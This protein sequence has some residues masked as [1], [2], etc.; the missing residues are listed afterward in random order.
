MKK[1]G[2]FYL[3]ARDGAKHLVT[4][5]LLITMW[6]QFMRSY[7]VCVEWFVGTKLQAKCKESLGKCTMEDM[8][9]RVI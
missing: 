9:H 4:A 6:W 2:S 5:F 3:L 7:D 8:N 1:Y